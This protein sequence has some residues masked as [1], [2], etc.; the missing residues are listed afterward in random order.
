MDGR[1]AEMEKR[2]TGDADLKV[3]CGFQTEAT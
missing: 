1:T 2:R 3:V